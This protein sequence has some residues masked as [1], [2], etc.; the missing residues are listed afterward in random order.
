MK[1]IIDKIVN[2]QINSA[3]ILKREV[4]TVTELFDDGLRAKVNIRDSNIIFFNKS[5]EELVI[6]DEV[7]IHYW[8]N[9]SNGWIAVKYGVPTPMGTSAHIDNAIVVYSGTTDYSYVDN[10]YNIELENNKV[11][12]YALGAWNISDT[13][14]NSQ[15]TYERIYINGYAATYIPPVILKSID[16]KETYMTYIKGISSDLHYKQVILPY[17]NTGSSAFS[18]NYVRYITYYVGLYDA[19]YEDSVWKYRYALFVS[20]PDRVGYPNPGEP[21]SEPRYEALIVSDYYTNSD[22]VTLDDVSFAMLYPGGFQQYDTLPA[23][24]KTLFVDNLEIEL[25]LVL[26]IRDEVYFYLRHSGSSNLPYIITHSIIPDEIDFIK[27]KISLL[28]TNVIS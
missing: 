19:K 20:D 22:N 3:N 24:S 21:E 2:A 5:G 26:I 11:T 25:E 17:Y 15:T 16:N 6:G 14:W 10:L 7:E 12:N 4:G 1:G 9:I 18:E 28:E 27:A 8:T 23:Y 13:T